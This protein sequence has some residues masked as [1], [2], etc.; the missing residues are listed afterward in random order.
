VTVSNTGNWVL[1]SLNYP[2]QF[3]NCPA[4]LNPTASA[5]CT[6]QVPLPAADFDKPA[7]QVAQYEATVKDTDEEA[8]GN[9]V[10]A[11]ISIDRYGLMEHLPQLTLD[12]QSNPAAVV[13]EGACDGSA[14]VH[15]LMDHQSV[16]T[17]TC[18][19]KHCKYALL[20]VVT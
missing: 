7:N 6:L 2:A 9:T 10:R 3:K 4:S 19:S 16:S 18:A 17:R 15:I 13:Q 11:E 20:H 8:A 5:T 14:T 12:L 1:S